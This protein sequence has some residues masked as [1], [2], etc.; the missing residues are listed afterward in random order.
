MKLP[1]KFFFEPTTSFFNF[2]ILISRYGSSLP[3]FYVI[4]YLLRIIHKLAE[5]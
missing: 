2:I 5:F 4:Q 1:D 3:V